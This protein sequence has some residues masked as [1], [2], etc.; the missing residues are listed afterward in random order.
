VVVARVP[1]SSWG[2]ALTMLQWFSPNVA[3]VFS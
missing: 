3:V 2:S 1:A